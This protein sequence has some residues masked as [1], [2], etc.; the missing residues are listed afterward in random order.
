MT[1]SSE[2][3]KAGPFAGNDVTTS[4][5]FVFKVFTSSDLEVVRADEDGIETILTQG[6]D[7]SV[8]LNANQ[9]TNPGGTVVLTSP[10]VVDTTLVLTSRVQ[11]L[12]P[13]DLTNQG[14]FYPKVINDA[15]DRATIQIQQLVEQV[16]R[17]AK[18]PI[19]SAADADSL[20]ADIVLLANN[21]ANINTVASGI[22]AVQTVADDIADVST[23]A[24]SIANVNATGGSIA[25]VNTVATNI[26][27][28]NS[29]ATN[30]AA[31]IAAPTQASNAAAS[32]S[33][34]SASEA[35][36]AAS[37]AAAAAS[38]DN[39]DDR[40]LGP[41]TSNP[42]V[43]N[44][45]NPLVTGALYYRS[46][47]PVGMKVY[48]GAQWIEASAAQQAALVTFEY[49]ATAGQTT[50]SGND[51]NGVPLSYIAGGLIVSLNGVI[52]RPGDDFTATSG[53]SVVLLSGASAG[54]ELCVYA[55]SSFVV[56]NTYTQAQADAAFL[57]KS[58]PSYTG[59]LTGGTGVVNLGS[60]QFF[61]DASGNVGIGTSSPA[62]RLHLRQDQDGT[63]R[64]IIQNRST[65]GTPLSELAFITGGFD[66]SDNRYA[67]IQS[68]GG[69]A[70]YIAFGTGNGA[71]PTE[72]ARIDSSGNLLVGTTSAIA[73]GRYSCQF[74]GS[75]SNGI[76]LQTTLASTG[77]DFIRLLNSAG[78]TCGEIEQNGTT[79]V[80]YLTSS[81]YRLKENIQPMTGALAKVAALKPVTYKWKVDGSDGQ[82][83]IA[84]ELQEV[85]PDAVSGEKDGVDADGQPKYQGIDTSFLV[86]TLAA[87][88]QEQQAII[89]ALTARVEALEA[90]A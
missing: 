61:K 2:V 33:A 10:L 68:G 51:A 62:S 74:N 81:D 28:V 8:N 72:R 6:T 34:A 53:I 56:A 1:I 43:D 84:H 55:F 47:A 24:G 25:N 29:A 79:T 69:G 31:I 82:G 5:P 17:S 78:N 26:T 13:T 38:L 75:T 16:D 52:L 3:R 39:F 11:N 60:G 85:C 70:Q 76:V 37:A 57:P 41:K 59:T 63:T 32:A 83:F 66:L 54:D 44:D 7:Y 30:M 58:N 45:G 23:V 88:I 49:V 71:A 42:T 73:S 12:Q 50:F 35:N 27:A 15:L 21:N 4:F 14:G 87:A 64:E 89:T 67:Y 18:L 77:T 40:Y 36:A 20:V 48:D 65:S 9:N 19:T 86:A 46:S 80:A 22:G 90:Q